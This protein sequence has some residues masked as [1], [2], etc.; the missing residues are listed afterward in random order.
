MEE[1]KKLMEGLGKTKVL[2]LSLF[3]ITSVVFV[4][5]VAGLFVNSLA[6]MSDAPCIPRRCN[7]FDPPSY[8][9]LGSEAA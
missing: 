9:T 1:S 3:A 5:G 7:Y 2:G 8:N 6:L 4:E